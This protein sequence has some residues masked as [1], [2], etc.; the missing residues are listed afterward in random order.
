MRR[1]GKKLCGDEQREKQ[2]SSSSDRRKREKESEKFRREETTPR[3]HHLEDISRKKEHLLLLTPLA[4]SSSRGCRCSRSCSRE[5]RLWL[6]LPVPAASSL[7]FKRRRDGR[8]KENERGFFHLF[9]FARRF[10]PRSISTRLFLPLSS[11]F[12]TVS[13]PLDPAAVYTIV[14]ASSSEGV[15]AGDAE[16]AATA[17]TSY[18]ADEQ[19]R[20][21]PRP[22]TDADLPRPPPVASTSSPPSAFKWHSAHPDRGSGWSQAARLRTGAAAL[23]ESG[24]HAGRPSVVVTGLRARALAWHSWMRDPFGTL[25]ALSWRSMLTTMALAYV[26]SFL[27]WASCWFWLSLSAPKCVLGFETATPT[28]AFVSAFLLSVEAQQTIGWGAR[29]PRACVRSAALETC[30]VIFG[31]LLTAVC[32]GVVFARVS[33][34][35][36][37]ARSVFVSEAACVARRKVSGVPPNSSSAAASSAAT[38]SLPVLSFRVADTKQSRDGGPTVSAHLFRWLS[39]DGEDL[40]SMGGN[41]A[42]SAAVVARDTNTIS[43][44]FLSSPFSPSLWRVDEIKL[45]NGEKLPPLFL[46]VTVEHV[47]DSSSPFFNLSLEDLLDSGAEVVVQVFGSSER[48]EYVVTRSYLASELHWGCGFAPCVKRAASSTSPSSTSRLGG[49]GGVRQ[50]RRGVPTNIPPLPPS[51]HVVDLSRFH[52]VVPLPGVAPTRVGGPP[53]PPAVVAAEVLGVA[54]GTRSRGEDV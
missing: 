3:A 12:P 50:R 41:G 34:P 5:V 42:A 39:H 43:P 7:S 48:G 30:Q 23:V 47:I 54:G 21:R 6:Y 36:R 9:R 15:R 32:A 17:T 46:P 20:R 35:R 14:G 49:G 18:E 13:A 44:S 10:R 22:A 52:E 27:L 31:Q 29:A 37:R 8:A 40:G 2:S 26:C 1:E 38:S 51:Q 53:R 19:G 24:R 45:T 25:L 33:H 28:T 11:R 4:L 16:T